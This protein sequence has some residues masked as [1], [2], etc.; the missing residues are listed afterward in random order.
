MTGALSPV[1]AALIHR[2]DAD[3]GL[4][5]AGDDVAGLDQDDIPLDLSLDEGVGDDR[6]VQRIQGRFPEL[7]GRDIAGGSCAGTEAWALPRPSAMD[8]GES[9]R[10]AP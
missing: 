4:S 2:G 5:V 6:G 7:L 10:R 8:F 3:D 1:M 9:W